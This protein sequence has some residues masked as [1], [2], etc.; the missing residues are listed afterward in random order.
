MVFFFCSESLEVD[1]GVFVALV[2]YADIPAIWSRLSGCVLM[3][4]WLF[5]ENLNNEFHIQLFYDL[6]AS[7]W[8]SLSVYIDK[9]AS[10]TCAFTR[11]YRGCAQ[12]RLSG[13]LCLS[14]SGQKG[15]SPSFMTG[16]VTGHWL[17]S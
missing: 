5:K 17:V 7:S 9:C 1:Y 15:L 12:A 8:M 10:D 14:I 3:T 11:M 4:I 2:S 13:C 16:C 6:E